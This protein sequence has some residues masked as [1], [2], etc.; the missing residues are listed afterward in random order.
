MALDETHDPALRSAVA[1]ANEPDAE[2]P[3][4]NLPFG[5]FSPAA[6]G[7][8]RVGVAIGREVLDLAA[9]RAGGL[10]RGSLAD[11][12]AACDQPSLNALLALGPGAWRA[13]RRALSAWLRRGSDASGA[14]APALH[15]AAHVTMHLPAVIGDY[16]DFYASIFHATTVGS[17]LRP[18]EPLLPNYKYVPIGYHGRASSVVPSGTPIVRPMGQSK[19]ESAMEPTFGP[20]RRLDYELEVGIVIGP[21]NAL[22]TPIPITD[23]EAHVFGLCLLNDWSARD[24]Q[25]WEYQPLGPFLAKS[26]A[27]SISPWLVTLDALEPFRVPAARRPEGDPAPLAYL[28]DPVNATR[29]GV[30]VRLEASLGT[31]RMREAGLEPHVVSRSTLRHLYWTIGQLVAHHTSNGCNLRPGDLLGTGTVSGPTRDSRGCLLELTWRGTEPLTLPGGETR[32]FLEDG[33]EVAFR[34]WCERDGA[35]RIGFGECRGVVIG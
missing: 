32:R 17:M 4:Q 33:D 3:I 21:G 7:P 11:V 5:V 19:P 1:S 6:G 16:T 20:S 10:F 14:V 24:V 13:L 23:A 9:C 28:A 8:P 30:D 25:Q 27:T 15:P 18:D 26:F 2:F 35:V 34:G 29:G 12:G 22:G 31:S